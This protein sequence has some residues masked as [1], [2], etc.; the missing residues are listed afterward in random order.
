MRFFNCERSSRQVTTR[1]VG[2]CVMRMA[3]SVVLTLC[4]PGPED[5]YV[6]LQVLGLDVDLHLLRFEQDRDRRR[7]GVDA[8]R[9]SVVG[10]RWTRCAPL[11]HLRCLAAFLP[12][13]LKMTSFEPAGLRRRF[14]HQLH[15]PSSRLGIFGVHAIEI[16]G[17]KARFLPAC[18]R[19]YFHNEVTVIFRAGGVH[20]FIELI[21]QR[22]PARVEFLQLGFWPG[23]R[24]P[25]SCFSWR[26]FLNS[27]V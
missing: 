6:D 17:E 2:K 3:E 24:T 11:S 27:S 1:P 9:A 7:R 12:L 21:G 18:S 22:L 20:Q 4:P 26:S 16:A 25:A 13:T 15:L 23:T 8:S 14:A 5:R 10:T 19:A